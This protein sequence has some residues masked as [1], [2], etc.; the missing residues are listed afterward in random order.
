MWESHIRLC[1]VLLLLAIP[2]AIADFFVLKDKGG[3]W[4]SLDFRGILTGAYLIIAGI[5][6]VMSSAAVKFFPQQALWSLHALSAPLSVIVFSAGVYV[7]GQWHNHRDWV[8]YEKTRASRSKLANVVALNGWKFSPDQ[9]NATEIIVSVSVSESGRF[10]CSAHGRDADE[11]S[12][13][14]LYSDGVKQRQVEKGEKFTHTLPLKRS[15]PGI[16]EVIEITL[17]L[18]ADSTGSA[19]TNVTKVFTPQPSR[20]D[21]GHFFY[22][23]LPPPGGNF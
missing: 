8:Q 20:D 9:E 11:Y 23:V 22:G 1:M 10:A 15:R 7:Y 17:Y 12:E 16:P 21:D 19:G 5:H 2:V 18:F 4:I 14:Y 3:G 13:W 6:V